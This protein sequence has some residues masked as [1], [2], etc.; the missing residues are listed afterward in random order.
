M[1]DSDNERRVS[2]RCSLM[3]GGGGV[4]GSG[5]SYGDVGGFGSFL[6]VPSGLFGRI[7]GLGAVPD[8][9]AGVGDS[10]ADV[11]VAAIVLVGVW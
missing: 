10:K 11:A 8:L 6:C 7:D 4:A 1:I 5:L 2:L 3:L 9:G